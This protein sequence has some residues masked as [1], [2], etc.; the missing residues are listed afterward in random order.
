MGSSVPEWVR[1][2]ALEAPLLGLILAL[3][4]ISWVTLSTALDLLV[5]QFPLL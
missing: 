3:L 1:L 4:L 2:Q 5:P